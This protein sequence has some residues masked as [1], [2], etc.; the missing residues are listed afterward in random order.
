MTETGN[1]HDRFFKDALLQPNATAD[2]IRYY[3]PERI[4]RL[5]IPES[6]EPLEDS[7]IDADLQEHLS[8]LLFRVK[9]KTGQEAYLYLLLEHKS[10]PDE[11]VALQ[12]LRYLVRIWD[13]S[14][15]AGVKKLPLV[16]PVVFYHGKATWKIPENFGALF[17]WAENLADLR[18]F[19]PEFRYHLCDLSKFA[20]EDLRGQT[21]LQASMRLLKHIFRD[22]LHDQLETVFRLIIENT[23]EK[24]QV[25]R[26]K[27]LINYLLRT[28]K[29][30]EK[31]V[32]EKL[33][34]T[35]EEVRRKVME[36][37]IDQWIAQGLQRG[38]QEGRQKGLQEG[39]QKG[40]QEGLQEGRQEGR[41]KGLQEG[42]L[43]GRR[44]EAIAFSLRLLKRKFG[45]LSRTLEKQLRTL[46]IKDLESLA[47]EIFDLETKEDL[48]NRVTKLV[49]AKNN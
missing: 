18:E 7:F 39:R 20:D 33:N 11:W 22:E 13:K 6:A 47:D 48:K 34:K 36:T 9:L 8:D 43:E 3:L 29:A 44:Q 37:V 15:R 17:D 21:E 31:E 4:S 28:G 38:L 35:N 12:L 30:G 45:Q 14:N 23:P 27:I 5:L 2:F 41:Q 25:D 26:L 16:I 1:L 42:L 40:L 32:A 10:F 49:S 19:I 46:E 24:N